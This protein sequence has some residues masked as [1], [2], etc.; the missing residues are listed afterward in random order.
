MAGAEVYE[1]CAT[2]MP[3]SAAAAASIDALRFA[4][5]AIS[6]S[7]GSRSMTARR[8]GVRSRMT[9]TTSNGSR[10]STKASVSARWSLKTTMLVRALTADQSASF[11][12]TFW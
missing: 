7:L 1:V 8:N 11:S 6:F 2:A 12:A 3:R 10:R 5:E 9:H 4:V